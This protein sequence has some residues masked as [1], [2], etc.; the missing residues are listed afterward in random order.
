MRGTL[1][2]LIL[3]ALRRYAMHGYSIAEFIEQSSDDVLRVEEGALYPALHRLELRGLLASKWGLSAN[4]RRAKFYRL[5]A[6]GRKHLAQENASWCRLS[7][8]VSRVMQK[9]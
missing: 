1:D 6:P 8:A 5:T 4:N 7:G 9:A 3:K 2:M